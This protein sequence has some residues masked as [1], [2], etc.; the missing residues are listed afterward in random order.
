MSGF[1]GSVRDR[2]SKTP[3]V[4]LSPCGRELRSTTRPAVCVVLRESDWMMTR[5]LKTE[6]KPWMSFKHI[7]VSDLNQNSILK[8]GLRPTFHTSTSPVS[9]IPKPA[10]QKIESR[11]H[12]RIHWRRIGAVGSRTGTLRCVGS[13]HTTGTHTHTRTNVSMLPMCCMGV[14]TCM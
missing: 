2:G 14:Y 10:A 9:S 6:F 5:G 8:P 1:V 4:Q 11:R 13:M 3:E 7:R 12:H